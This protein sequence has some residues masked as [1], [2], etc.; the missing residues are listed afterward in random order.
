MSP[1]RNI[2]GEWSCNNALSAADARAPDINPEQEKSSMPHVVV[3]LHA[4]RS[5]QQKSELA[6][7]ITAAVMASVHSGE[8]AVSVGIEDIEPADWTDR[9]YKPDIIGKRHTLYKQPGYNPL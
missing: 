6:A 3:K 8:A 2:G 1:T 5:E 4:G 9:V 7:R